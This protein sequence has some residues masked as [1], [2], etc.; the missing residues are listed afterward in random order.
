M[1]SIEWIKSRNEIFF[2]P[3]FDAKEASFKFKN[4]KSNL[5][6]LSNKLNIVSFDAWIDSEQQIASTIQ[7]T[8][9]E[10]YT[11]NRLL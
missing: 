4:E 2:R 3:E 7:A 1:Q 8:D 5:T 6:Q 9:S 11:S 10:H